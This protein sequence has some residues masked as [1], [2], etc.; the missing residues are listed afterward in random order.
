MAVREL[1][2]QHLDLPSDHPGFSDQEYRAR[3]AAIARSCASYQPGGP[4]DDVEY[5]ADEDDVWRVVSTQL[6]VQH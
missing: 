1:S 6:A 3:R 5:T 2:Q 4:I